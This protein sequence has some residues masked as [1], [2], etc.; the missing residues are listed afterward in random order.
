MSA[1]PLQ[2]IVGANE[3]VEQTM[4]SPVYEVHIHR[5]GLILV[6]GL[7]DAEAAEETIARHSPKNFLPAKRIILLA[8]L[9][10]GSLNIGDWHITVR[11]VYPGTT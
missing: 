10:H 4:T 2:G 7:F 3:G 6:E 1:R 9:N 8:I 5:Q 11:R